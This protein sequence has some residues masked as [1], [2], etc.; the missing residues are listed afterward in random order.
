LVALREGHC[1]IGLGCPGRPRNAPPSP[2]PNEWIP[3]AAAF[4]GGPGG[5]APWRVSGQSPNLLSLHSTASASIRRHSL[6]GK[7][8]DR[9]CVFRKIRQSHAAQHVR[10]LGEL[11]V[12]VANDL[13]AVAPGIAE[14]EEA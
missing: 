13:D 1:G 14:V 7:F 9:L 6:V 4:G 3:K 5:K 12:V 2:Q 8:L 11:D 10:R